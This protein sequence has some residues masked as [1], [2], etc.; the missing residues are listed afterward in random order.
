MKIVRCLKKELQDAQ[1]TTKTDVGPGIRGHSFLQIN[2]V[3][4]PS[5]TPELRT[6][7]GGKNQ[8]R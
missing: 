7:V 6:L 8:D 5:K 2:K 1:V 4:V 3:G